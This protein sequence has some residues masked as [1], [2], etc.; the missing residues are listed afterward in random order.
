MLKIALEL[1]KYTTIVSIATILL[2]IYGI[3]VE[4]VDAKSTI[5][6][7]GFDG[8]ERR[9]NKKAFL[10]SALFTFMVSIGAFAETTSRLIVLFQWHDEPIKAAVACNIC[11]ILFFVCACDLVSMATIELRLRWIRTKVLNK[12]K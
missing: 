12:E 4:V 2:L 5:T 10:C 3:M 1:Y 9:L 7:R 11:Y 6:D 8:Q